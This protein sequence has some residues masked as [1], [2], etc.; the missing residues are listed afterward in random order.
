MLKTLLSVISKLC[1][2]GLLITLL[3]T[4][5]I[6]STVCADVNKIIHT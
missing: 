4:I 2:S 5:L 6:K 1:V 3:I